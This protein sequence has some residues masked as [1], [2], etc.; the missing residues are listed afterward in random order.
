MIQ[1]PTQALTE[2]DQDLPAKLDFF[3]GSFYIKIKGTAMIIDNAAK[4]SELS[5]EGEDTTGMVA[6]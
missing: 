1:R 2:F 4:L 5:A 3:R 6:I